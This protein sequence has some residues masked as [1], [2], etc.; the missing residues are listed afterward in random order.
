[1]S[2]HVL[3]KVAAQ[4]RPFGGPQGLTP[5][6]T[7]AA[8]E[9]QLARVEGHRPQEGVLERFPHA[10]APVRGHGG[11]DAEQDLGEAGAH[12]RGRKTGWARGL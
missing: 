8:H 6:V 10:R 7:V 11:G 5:R 1:M 3:E 12:G 9:S 4:D 2:Q